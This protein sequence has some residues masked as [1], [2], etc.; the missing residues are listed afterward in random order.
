VSFPLYHST[1]PC[2]VDASFPFDV[3]CVASFENLYAGEKA[4]FALVRRAS[5]KAAARDG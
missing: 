3:D 4:T 5:M 1:F 2:N